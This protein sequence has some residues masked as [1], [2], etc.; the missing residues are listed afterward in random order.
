MV[1]G[2]VQS[3]QQCELGKQFP[4]IHKVSAAYHVPGTPLTGQTINHNE[5]IIV[6]DDMLV[7]DV[8]VPEIDELKAHYDVRAPY[9]MSIGEA[10]AETWDKH[11]AQ[12][13]VLAAR[14]SAI[15]S[16]ADGGTQ[17]TEAGYAT[18]GADIATGIFAAAEAM[19]EKNLPDGSRYAALR[20]AQ[21]YL[22]AQTTNVLNRDWGGSGAYAEG[23]VLKVAGI[24]IEKTNHVPS[25]LVASGPA[26][27]QGDFSNTQFIVW[28]EEAVG[29]VK[30]RDATT[31]VHPQPEKLGTLIY[32]KMAVG[33]DYL[34]PEAAVEGKSA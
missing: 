26:K 19:D 30:L 34:R 9:T 7:A 15:V 16:G 8:F 1:E 20:P 17:L 11:T 23:T 6:V 33:S 32:G 25:T 28:Q 24:S 22:L 12:L 31:I 14:A 5:R 13:I 21:Y 27:Y 3:S 10:L 4:V 29:T 2:I 18:T